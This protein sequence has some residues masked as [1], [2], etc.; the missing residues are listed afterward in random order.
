MK[1]LECYEQV[2]HE[3]KD[4]R[5]KEGHEI[6]EHIDQDAEERVVDPNCQGFG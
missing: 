5:K 6:P 1:G 4:S 2:I 3:N